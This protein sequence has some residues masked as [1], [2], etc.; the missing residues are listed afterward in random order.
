MAR[1]IYEL[2]EN[3]FKSVTFSGTTTAR[4]YD[5]Q[6]SSSREQEASSSGQVMFSN[7]NTARPTDSRSNSVS[8][9]WCYEPFEIIGK[10]A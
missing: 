3:Q 9:I 4:E 8:C 2:P 1:L 6:P 10:I 7:T 5:S